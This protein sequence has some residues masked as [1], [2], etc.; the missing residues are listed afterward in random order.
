MAG[1]LLEQAEQLLDR[2]I[3]P[4][5][6]ADGYDMAAKVALKRLD[7][8]S[9]E[10]PVSK[11]DTQPLIR[12]AMTTLSSKMYARCRTCMCVTLYAWLG[13]RGDHWVDTAA[14]RCARLNHS[15][16]NYGIAL[17]CGRYPDRWAQVPMYCFFA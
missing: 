5:R 13:F 12:T 11:D 6:I 3:H 14:R 8:I 9:E 17:S 16:C 4:I 2:G 7:E 10:Y 1:A 15:H